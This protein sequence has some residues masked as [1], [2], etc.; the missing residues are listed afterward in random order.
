MVF[1]GKF[2]RCDKRGAGAGGAVDGTLT[3]EEWKI[4]IKP[5]E[6]IGGVGWP[7]DVAQAEARFKRDERQQAREHCEHAK[8]PPP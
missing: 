8:P 3:L 7:A 5:G 2:L 1:R 6:R 4:S